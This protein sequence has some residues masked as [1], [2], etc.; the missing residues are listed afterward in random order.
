MKDNPVVKFV[1][2]Q[3]KDLENKFLE[4]VTCAAEPDLPVD[5]DDPYQKVSKK[6]KNIFS[7]DL[8]L[9][10]IDLNAFKKKNSRRPQTLSQY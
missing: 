8:T 2:A 7:R 9:F 1:Y 3:F 6:Q 10:Q 4:E 5:I